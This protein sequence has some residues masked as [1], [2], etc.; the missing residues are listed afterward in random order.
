MNV[1]TTSALAVLSA[2]QLRELIAEAVTEAQRPTESPWRTAEQLAD[3]LGVSVATVNRRVRE[4]LP[5]VRLHE[6][7][8]RMFYTPDVDAWLRRQ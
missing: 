6:G 3:Y 2:D 8:R 1:S 7:G 4:G 5:F